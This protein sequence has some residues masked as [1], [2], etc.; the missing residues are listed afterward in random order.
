MLPSISSLVSTLRLGQGLPGEVNQGLVWES[1][2]TVI[3]AGSRHQSGCSRRSTPGRGHTG[4]AISLSEK[5]L[6]S[7]VDD[8]QSF[9]E[10]MRRL[11]ASLGY[12]V[13]EFPSAAEFLES[14]KRDATA[15][16]VADIQ[17]PT[18]TGVELFRRL[19]EAGCAI[20]TILVTA[21]PDVSVRERMLTLGVAG[22]LAKPLEEAA[23]IGCLRSVFARGRAPWDAS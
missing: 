1:D 15:C 2:C 13:A 6:I 19:H 23:L 10:S 21:Y 7:V 20:P 18:M 17:M 3:I 8:D 12:S 9:R 11:L 16:L 22:Y 14:R 4:E 5:S